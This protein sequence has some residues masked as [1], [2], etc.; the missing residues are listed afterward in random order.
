MKKLAVMLI[1]V[2]IGGC[3]D[4]YVEDHFDDDVKKAMESSCGGDAS[5][6]HGFVDG[7]GF[8]L[9]TAKRIFDR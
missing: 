2:A 4:H 3:R 7:V 8:G 9:N 1:V 5:C 6:R